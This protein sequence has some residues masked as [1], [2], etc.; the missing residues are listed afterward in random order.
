MQTKVRTDP[1]L[2]TDNEERIKDKMTELEDILIATDMQN[3]DW[4]QMSTAVPIR[5]NINYDIKSL[6]EVTT[7]VGEPD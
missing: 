4:L 3:Q 2:E 5:T 1:V 7:R 6:L